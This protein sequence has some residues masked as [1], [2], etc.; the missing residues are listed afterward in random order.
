MA[1]YGFIAWRRYRV[2]VNG[3]EKQRQHGW[4]ALRGRRRKLG[5]GCRIARSIS[6]AGGKQSAGGSKGIKSAAKRSGV[7]AGVNV[8]N[9]GAAGHARRRQRASWRRS[10]LGDVARAGRRRRGAGNMT[11]ASA[12]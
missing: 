1:V 4:L 6:S 10:T 7:D 5:R 12:A 2:S 11:A 8:R 9:R 3:S